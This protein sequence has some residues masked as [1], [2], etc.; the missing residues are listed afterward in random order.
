MQ[1][2][3]GFAGRSKQNDRTHRNDSS[4][5][6]GPEREKGCAVLSA[7]LTINCAT[8]SRKLQLKTQN[9]SNVKELGGASGTREK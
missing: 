6:R 3:R 1:V 7:T 2:N 8:R 5:A 9:L 4:T